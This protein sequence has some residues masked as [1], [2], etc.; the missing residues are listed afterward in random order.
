MAQGGA[1]VPGFNAQSL[2]R[3]QLL[4]LSDTQTFGPH[5]VNELNLSFIRDYIVLGKPIG[6][7]GVVSSQGFVTA[8][9]TP[10]IA[11]LAPQFEGVENIIF[12]SFSI[13]TNTNQ[14]KQV[15]NTY[16]TL[17]D[18]HALRD[19]TL[20]NSE[21]RRTMIRS[22][23]TRSLNLTE[24]SYSPGANGSDFADFLLGVPMSITKVN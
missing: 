15:N 10:S 1:S 12:N 13:G 8:N 16:H 19:P 2:G 18:T 11:A 22:T 21:A 17:T 6:G 4:S 23:R 14:L 5:A 24:A 20:L 3:A 9:G 7:L